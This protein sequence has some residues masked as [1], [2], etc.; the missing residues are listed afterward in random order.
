MSKSFKKYNV[1]AAPTKE[2]AKA[3]GCDIS[4]LKAIIKKGKGAYYSS[5]S[6]PEQSEDSWAYARL[7][8][9]SVGGP[10]SVVDINEIEKGCKKNSQM[11]KLARQQQ[12][13]KKSLK[14]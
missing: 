10:A 7:A 8:S 1:P 2:F 13:K 3:T 5:G 12:R 6:R 9:S 11:L 4:T 14:K